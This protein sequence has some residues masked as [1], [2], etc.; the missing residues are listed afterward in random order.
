MMSLFDKQAN[1]I[2]TFNNTSRYLDDILNINNVSFDMN[3]AK[4]FLKDQC[5]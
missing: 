1:I 2:D 3:L 5:L 4:P